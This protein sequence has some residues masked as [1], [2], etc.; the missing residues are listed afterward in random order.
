M[1]EREDFGNQPKIVGDRLS[2]PYIVGGKERV[3]MTAAAFVIDDLEAFGRMMV[4]FA[5]LHEMDGEMP[6]MEIVDRLLRAYGV[7][8]VGG[9]IGVDASDVVRSLI[10]TSGLRRDH[11]SGLYPQ[12]APAAR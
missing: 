12:Q 6:I 5:A 1:T 4:R 8:Y 2:N 10:Q 3:G 7:R 9:F 11:L